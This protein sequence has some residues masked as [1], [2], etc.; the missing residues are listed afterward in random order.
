[1]VD[2]F[3][4]ISI[5]LQIILTYT[6]II[7]ACRWGFYLLKSRKAQNL[8]TSDISAEMLGP[9][10]TTDSNKCSHGSVQHSKRAQSSLRSR[11]SSPD[12]DQPV[13]EAHTGKRRR[14][15]SSA[16]SYS[17][18]REKNPPLSPPKSV[19]L[20]ENFCS[21][22]DLFS[23][24]LPEPHGQASWEIQARM[25]GFLKPPFYA[26][27]YAC[28]KETEDVPIGLMELFTEYDIARDYALRLMACEFLRI[29]GKSWEQVLGGN[30]D[31]DDL[32]CKAEERRN[33]QNWYAEWTYG[34]HY[35][36]HVDVTSWH[37]A[38][39]MTKGYQLPSRRGR[40][41]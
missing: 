36:Q 8:S 33:G 11:L 3:P 40:S 10:M 25:H 23:L 19:Q 31:D 32:V 17:T 2:L 20:E 27:T 18:G 35:R 6:P 37:P 38:T 7:F 13:F 4:Y 41:G 9:E 29:H 22:D 26:V 1:M 12:S 15:D 5:L 30:T 16:S 24:D 14:Q 34:D 28:S 21:D 39:Q